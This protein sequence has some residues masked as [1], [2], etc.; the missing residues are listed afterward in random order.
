[1]ASTQGAALLQDEA[2]GHYFLTGDSF[3]KIYD[4]TLGTW[5]YYLADPQRPG[6]YTTNPRRFM[7]MV[8]I[9]ILGYIPF[10]FSM[11]AV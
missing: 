11:Q 2:T 6:H 3:P 1:M 10:V 8:P 4:F 5:I 7:K 9:P